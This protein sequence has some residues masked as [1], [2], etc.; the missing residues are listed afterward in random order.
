MI[1][2]LL[3]SIRQQRNLTP[4]QL[5]TAAGCS[6][7]NINAYELGQRPIPT[8]ILISLASACGV[9]LSYFLENGNRIGTF[10]ILQEDL[11]HFSA[12]PENVR[13]FVSAPVN[14]PYIELAMKLSQMGTDQLRGIAE[15]ILEITL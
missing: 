4:D 5:A 13:H 2:A 9:N 1:G 6:V 15:A 3:R 12:L 14:Q 7:S 10:L 8:P 11:K